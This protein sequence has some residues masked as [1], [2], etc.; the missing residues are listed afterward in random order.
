MWTKYKIDAGQSIQWQI[1][2]LDY[3]F[4]INNSDCTLAIKRIKGAQSFLL[5]EAS[6]IKSIQEYTIQSFVLDRF[7]SIQLL[8]ALP[9][10]PIMFKPAND[11]H[12]LPG[13]S[14]W[15]FISIPVTLDIF[16]T[17]KQNIKSLIHKAPT[18]LLSGA[19]HGE[20]DN[21]VITY[22][23]KREAFYQVEESKTMEYEV[24]CPYQIKNDSDALLKID[25]LLINS[26]H[27]KIFSLG[28]NLYTNE[29]YMKFDGSNKANYPQF[30]K[31]APHIAKSAELLTNESVAPTE[32]L[33]KR[34]LIYLKSG[35]N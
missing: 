35:I 2:E 30:G 3:I 17:C 27:L 23:I 11:I 16:I 4:S 8:P 12:I 29:V 34:R 6:H 10:R 13:K 18:V 5:P 14:A 7:D 22:F 9:D 25:K 20:S 1:G 19:W 28:K 24:I 31:T 32:N 26:E 21:G 33:L 15:L